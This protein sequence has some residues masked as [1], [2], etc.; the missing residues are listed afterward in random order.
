MTN[1]HLFKDFCKLNQI[2]K[3]L[4]YCLVLEI[5]TLLWQIMFKKLW[6]LYHHY[7]Y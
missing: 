2:S 5:L 4:N 3:S 1:L 7:L 6:P